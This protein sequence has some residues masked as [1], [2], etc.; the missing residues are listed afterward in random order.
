MTPPVVDKCGSCMLDIARK[1]KH[2][3][4]SGVCGLSFHVDCTKMKEVSAMWDKL[5]LIEGVKWFCAACNNIWNECGTA[6]IVTKMLTDNLKPVIAKAIEPIKSKIKTL[7]T[8]SERVNNGVDSPAFGGGKRRRLDGTDTPVSRDKF[9]NTYRDKLVFGTNENAGENTKLKG[10]Q[11]P[12]DE[13]SGDFKSIYLSQLDPSTEPKDIIEYLMDSKVIDSD[14][15]IKCIKLVS[16]KV[17]SDTFTYV[18][19]K[20]DVPMDL[21]DKLVLPAIWP[22]SVAVRE[23][24]HKPRPTA[25]L[26]KN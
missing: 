1:D 4:C 6:G 21:Y 5:R 23:F 20:L 14:K 2:I 10:V 8:N 25:S 12:S 16:P 15:L 24:V 22:K 7:A 19:F 3:Q 17:N 26:S 13:M 9:S 18:S 11:K